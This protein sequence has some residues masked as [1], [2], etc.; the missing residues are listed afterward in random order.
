MDPTNDPE[1]QK[2]VAGLIAVLPAP[3][4]NFFAEGKV[5]P[6]ARM[7]IE[8]YAL[9]IDQ[10]AVVGREIIFLLLGIKSP[11]EFAA[12]L[13]QDANIPQATVEAIMADLNER[14]FV[15]LQNEIRKTAP[16]QAPIQ[17]PTPRPAP[18]QVPVPSYTPPPPP[19]APRVQP[20]PPPPPPPQRPA[21]PVAPQPQSRAPA[22][23]TTQRGAP[24][25]NLP[26][27]GGFDRMLEDR[28]EPHIEVGD[29][30]QQT[31]DRNP[32]PQQPPRPPQQSFL[33]PNPPVPPV[34]SVQPPLPPPSPFPASPRTPEARP[35][36]KEYGVDPYRESIE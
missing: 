10:G 28:E 4:R 30:R 9:R 11:S 32:A 36:L 34:R 13:V 14:V 31:V 33:R 3:V 18:Q 1:F 22:A 19:Q 8:K 24:P 25:S 20:P 7:L 17:A 27:T 16:L 29:S 6:V 26:G 23:P 35:I 5:G 15:P 12:A 21:A 2:S